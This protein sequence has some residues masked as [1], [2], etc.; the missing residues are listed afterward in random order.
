MADFKVSISALD[1]ALDLVDDLGDSLTNYINVISYDVRTMKDAINQKKH[2]FCEKIDRINQEINDLVSKDNDDCSEDDS[3]Q[4]ELLLMER[5]LYQEKLEQCSQLSGAINEIET[6]MSDRLHLYSSGFY[7]VSSTSTRFIAD[8]IAKLQDICGASTSSRVMHGQSGASCGYAVCFIDKAK[9]PE[10]AEH[11]QA[12]ITAGYSPV[13]TLGRSQAS[14][15]RKASLAAFPVSSYYDRDEYPPAAFEEGGN[16]AHVCYMSASD[17][18]GS[19]SSFSH[20]LRNIPDGTRVRF[21][22]I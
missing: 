10:S 14:E 6:E 7:D 13:L 22:V 19:G 18:R 9:Y 1:S 12:A 16:G 15:R 17:N 11:I 5:N 8:Y 4:L 21:R 20:Q 3:S 2:V